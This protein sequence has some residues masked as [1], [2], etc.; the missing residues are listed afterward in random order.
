MIGWEL[1]RTLA[2]RLPLA[3]LEKAI[4]ERK[5]FPGVAI[6]PTAAS[7]T[8]PALYPGRASETRYGPEHE[9]TGQSIRQRQLRELHEDSQTGGDLC[10][11]VP[12]P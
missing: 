8:H 1:D 2:A 11:R 3:A 12:R 4:A 7:S 10:Q 5:P 6:I 9:P